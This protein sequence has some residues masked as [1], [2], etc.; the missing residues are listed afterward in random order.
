MIVNF[1]GKRYQVPD[2]ATDDEIAVAIDSG[3][4]GSDEGKYTNQTYHGQ[5]AIDFVTKREGELTAEQAEVVKW[6][7]FRDEIY[8]DSKDIPTYGVGQTGDYMDG[9]FKDAFESK[10]RRAAALIDN[11]DQYPEYLRAQLMSSMYRGDLPDSPAFI[12]LFNA[13]EYRAAAKEYLN[14]KE[15]LTTDRKQIQ[16]RL[17]ATRD[18]V[19]K[20]AT[21]QE[22]AKLVENVPMSPFEG[23][24]VNED[25]VKG[26]PT[27]GGDTFSM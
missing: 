6:E 15:Y 17:E 20:Y 26:R 14:H 19:L 12:K 1:E 13:G 5:D 7:G 9:T 11:F 3:L 24:P 2:D 21:E 18:A 16:E 22:A 8:K 4:E 27:Q 25:P 23:A 10:R